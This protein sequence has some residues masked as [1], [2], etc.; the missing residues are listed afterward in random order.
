MKHEKIT[1]ECSVFD[2]EP[3]NP[4]ACQPVRTGKS[5]P[6]V[7]RFHDAELL[8]VDSDEGS[9]LLNRPATFML[10]ALYAGSPYRSTRDGKWKPRTKS[11]GDWFAGPFSVHK[12]DA[13]KEGT[14]FVLGAA[15]DNAR[16]AKAMKTMFAIGLDIDSGARLDDVLEKIESLG[17]IAFVYTTH[18]H[19]KTELSLK[20]DDVMRKLKLSSAPTLE[21]VKEYLRE[22]A[23]DRYEHEFISAVEIVDPERQTK[24]GIEIMLSTPPLDKFRLIFPLAEPVNIPALDPNHTKCLEIWENKVTGFAVNTL[25]VSFDVACTDPSRLFFMPRHAEGAKWRSVYVRG[26]PLAFDDIAPMSKAF[27]AKNRAAA[28]NPLALAGLDEGEGIPE[29]FTPSGKSLREWH[30]MAKS[31]YQMADMLEAMAPDR[32]RR[33]GGEKAGTVHLECPFEHEHSKE[34]GTGTWA[35]NALDSSSE[36]WFIQCHHDACQGRHKTEFLAQMLE[37]QWFDESVLTDADW[38][39]PSDDDDDVFDDGEAEA[40]TRDDIGSPEAVAAALERANIDGNSNDAGVRKFMRRAL[41]AGADESDWG[42]IV[43]ALAGVTPLKKPTLNRMWGDE[44][45]EHQRREAAAREAAAHRERAA[46][47]AAPRRPHIALADATAE[48]VLAAAK[49]A[50]WLPPQFEV[51]GD[52]FYQKNFDEPQKALK[53]CRVFEVVGIAYQEG[54]RDIE[55]TIRFEH[56]SREK[57]GIVERSFL[58]A[59]TVR[60]A[61]EVVAGLV[62]DGLMMNAATGAHENGALNALKNLL[63]SIETDREAHIRLKPG[64]TADQQV[65][66]APSGEVVGGEADAYLLA[67]AMRTAKPRGELAEWREA[68]SAACGGTNGG[69]MLMGLL[70]GFAGCAADFVNWDTSPVIAFEGASSKGKSTAQKIGA[71]VWGPP[72]HRGLLMKADATPTAIETYAQRGNGAVVALDD[73]GASKIDAA[74]KQ[75][76]VLQ[77]S[78]GQGKG[79]GKRDGGLRAPATWRTCFTISAERGFAESCEA[80]QLKDASFDVKSGAM[81]RIISINFDD[82]V[83]LRR[84]RPADADAVLAAYDFFKEGRAYGVAGP[85]F[86]GALLALGPDAVRERIAAVADDMAKDASAVEMRVIR[87]AAVLIVCGEIANESGL[88]PNIDIHKAISPLVTASLTRRGRHLDVGRQQLET[89]RMNIRQAVGTGELPEDGDATVNYRGIVGLWK[90]DPGICDDGT[91]AAL[92]ARTYMLPV[93]RLSRLGVKVAAETLARQLREAGGLK[94]PNPNGRWAKEGFWESMPK[95]EKVKNIRVTGPFVHG[96][97]EWGEEAAEAAK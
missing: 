62:G 45:R 76:L 18:S 51:R 69:H 97:T 44:K 34:G 95:E 14:C 21:Q 32:I 29:F 87:N 10:G 78:E 35:G 28:S 3:A 12:K 74:E 60:D 66:V 4:P 27:Y 81:A 67:E 48:T 24:S 96:F 52:W 80:H 15:V 41:T 92:S 70:S 8:G 88:P 65:Y 33:A 61:G 57:V 53:V 13:D 79:R 37:D 84:D 5:A 38:L 73:E 11:W 2:D 9:A 55:V 63:R 16:M 68:A 91:E 23:K 30:R 46:R 56:R 26:R 75:R 47:R 43:E 89:L 72:D 77:W 82:V 85:V 22:H 7:E 58:L 20:R 86:A 94:E 1:D 93:E 50:S 54:G 40:L 39:T 71:S 19:G 17:L 42:R 36:Y 31:R 49:D 6:E 64:W 83:D 59:D 90:A 25:G